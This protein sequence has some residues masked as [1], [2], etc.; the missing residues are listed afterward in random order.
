MKANSAKASSLSSGPTLST[1]KSGKNG[2]STEQYFHIKDLR[3]QSEKQRQTQ[4][5]EQIYHNNL[6]VL[7]IEMTPKIKVIYPPSKLIK[8]DVGNSWYAMITDN[9]VDAEYT[10][11]TV[12]GSPGDH[13][14]WAGFETQMKGT[15]RWMNLVIPG[16]DGLD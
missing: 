13:R 15:V 2:E 5:A 12:H 8:V 16:F 4:E 9:Q 14:E 11:L 7:N 3:S 1:V 10:V 6:K